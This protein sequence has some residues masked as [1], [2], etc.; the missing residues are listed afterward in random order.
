MTD[1]HAYILLSDQKP[2]LCSPGYTRI[3][4]YG[5]IIQP[6]DLGLT[7]WAN[8][9]IDGKYTAGNITTCAFIV[10]DFPLFTSVQL[11]PNQWYNL[12]ADI[13]A[14]PDAPYLFDY[15]LAF[16]PPDP[17]PIST[18]STASSTNSNSASA[19]VTPTTQSP[20]SKDST[21]IPHPIAVI[22]GIAGACALLLALLLVGLFCWCRGRGS[23][24]K[25][26]GNSFC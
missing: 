19:T 18:S 17:T 7:A 13:W 2:L 24:P 14:S 26:I 4:V 15:L 25:K 10:T 8:Y 20:S 11:D 5:S 9:T 21:S 3:A 16:S 12:T 23:K 6:S 1:I 22:G